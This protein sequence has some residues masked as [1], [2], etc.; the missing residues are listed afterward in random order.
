LEGRVAETEHD[1]SKKVQ[2][3]QKE[4][5]DNEQRL[6]FESDEN[7]KELVQEH[8]RDLEG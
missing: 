4:M 5:F 1:F 7:L 6:R 2:D 8:R 3:L